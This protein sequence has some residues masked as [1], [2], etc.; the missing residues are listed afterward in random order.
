[1]PYAEAIIGDYQGGLKWGRSTVDQ[2]LLCDKYWK[3]FGNRRQ[4]YV[5]YILIFKKHMTLYGEKK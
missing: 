4:M 2:T 1:M 5:I 3:N